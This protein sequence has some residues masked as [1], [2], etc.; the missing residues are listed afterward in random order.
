MYF[1]FYF[2]MR[3]CSKQINIVGGGGAGG[4]G[5]DYD[6]LERSP[7][8]GRKGGLWE[9]RQGVPWRA[10]PPSMSGQPLLICWWHPGVLRHCSGRWWQDVLLA[11]LQAGG[12]QVT[13]SQV[14]HLVLHQGCYLLQ[15]AGQL[16]LLAHGVLLQGTDD[17]P[18]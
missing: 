15:A 13:S 2:Q 9:R 14:R 12:P 10:W 6:K 1:Y 3:F 16:H 11:P 5:K 17:L 4:R 7:G 8:R 18:R